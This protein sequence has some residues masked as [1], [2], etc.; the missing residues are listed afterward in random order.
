[1]SL[2]DGER[3]TEPRSRGAQ[4]LV[5]K[6]MLLADGSY[7][8]AGES[9]SKRAV[10]TLF[11]DAT[12]FGLGVLVGTA[13]ESVELFLRPAHDVFARYGLPNACFLDGGPGFV[14]DDTDRVFGQLGI[15]LVHGT[16]H[17]EGRGK[18]ERYHR[19]RG[20]RTPPPPDEKRP[21]C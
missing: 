9:H 20:E 21:L 11:D 8:R 16:G 17:A 15:H 2:A 7:F 3:E 13:G 12:R 4:P 18:I 5:S 14:A 10:L 6:M 1:M 19:T